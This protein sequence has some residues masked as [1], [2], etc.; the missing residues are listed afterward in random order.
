VGTI[1]SREGAFVKTR[2]ALRIGLEWLQASRYL[3]LTRILFVIELPAHKAEHIANKKILCRHPFLILAIPCTASL[4][5]RFSINW[6]KSMAGAKWGD[7]FP[8][9]VSFLIRRLSPA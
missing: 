2:A 8:S 6:F 5:T 9:A 3:I 7:E 4:W 1:D